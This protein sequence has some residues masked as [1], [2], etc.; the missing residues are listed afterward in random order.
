MKYIN[1][2]PNDNTWH[3]CKKEMP[4]MSTDVEFLDKDGNIIRNGHIFVDMSGAYAA[5]H[6]D[7]V[8]VWSSF[9]RYTHW[10]FLNNK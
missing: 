4:T 7:G 2:N 5:L 1:I 10:R 9:D 3:N 6:E 8:C